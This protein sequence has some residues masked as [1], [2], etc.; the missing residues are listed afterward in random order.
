MSE[1]ASSPPCGRLALEDATVLRGRAFGAKAVRLGEAVFNTSL[2]GYQETLTD[3]S[4]TGQI[5]VMTAPQIG[6][7][8]CTPE[9]DESRRM[10]ASGLVV[11]DLSPRVSSWRASESLPQRLA[12]EGVPGV[13]DLDTRALTLRLRDKGCLRAAICT[14]ASVSDEQ[15]VEMARAWPGLDG[16]DLTGEVTCD[17]PY[18][19]DEPTSPSWQLA[20][21][22]AVARSRVVVLDFGVKRNILRRLVSMGCEVTVVPATTTASEVLALRPDGIV[23]SNGPGDPGALDDIVHTAHALIAAEIPL[24]GIC[25]GHQILGRAL[26]ARTYRLKFG[27]HGG[28]QPVRHVQTAHVEISAHNHNFA[29]DA[30]TLPD[31]VRVSHVN[32]NDGCCEG[33][34][35]SVLPIISIQYHPEAAPG[36]HDADPIFTRFTSAMQTTRV[37]A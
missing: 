28:N 14:D 7:T 36:P 9:D 16:A 32:L 33:F 35:H 4:Y 1:H 17:K 31:G 3:P 19:W 22:P 27:H 26:G 13:S 24:L 8:G 10:F 25:L 11:R 5:I 2:T 29:V 15:L 20:A 37:R 23:L 30:A 18:A 12:R 34:E 21:D 6:N